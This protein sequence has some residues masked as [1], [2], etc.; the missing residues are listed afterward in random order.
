MISIKFHDFRIFCFSLANGR[1]SETFW[2]TPVTSTYLLAFIVSH[3]T[4]VSTNNNAL[5]PFDI[6]ARNNV[7]RTGDWSL[8]IGEKLLEAMEAY[9]QIPYYT[10]AENINMKQAAIPDFS[11]GAMENWGLLTY[12][13]KSTIILIPNISIDFS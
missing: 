6:Y 3:Y 10:M 7:G 11:A 2:T 8:E 5:R 12:R 1:V 4:V 9:T 13:Y